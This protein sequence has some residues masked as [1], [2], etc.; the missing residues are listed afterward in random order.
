MS[1]NIKGFPPEMWVTSVM[2]QIL[3]SMQYPEYKDTY[4]ALAQQTVDEHSKKRC[5]T[6][7]QAGTLSHMIRLADR[8]S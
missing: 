6:L 4:L 7:E 5:I 8:L 3:N 1:K 2:L